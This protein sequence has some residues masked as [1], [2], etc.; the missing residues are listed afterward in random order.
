V[1]VV[2]TLEKELPISV[3]ENRQLRRDPNEAGFSTPHPVGQS[4]LSAPVSG[5]G[6]TN[7]KEKVEV[8]ESAAVMVNVTVNVPF[9]P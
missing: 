8:V 9:D 7:V 4:G 6:I 5:V 2:L 1:A 3:G